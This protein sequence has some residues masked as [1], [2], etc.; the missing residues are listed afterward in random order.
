MK[1]LAVAIVACAAF[2]AAHAQY[3][4]VGPDG[5]VTYTDRPQPGAASVSGA[6]ARSGDVALPLV[7]REATTRFPVTLYT[8]TDCAPC[9][10][11][12]RLLRERGIPHQERIASA[13][14]SEA[15][16]AATG[17]PHVPALMIGRQVLRGFLPSQWHDY[18][19]T[20]GYPRESKL[21]PNYA[22]APALPLVERPAPPQ[23]APRAPEPPPPAPGGFR[24]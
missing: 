9:A 10:G 20:A 4:V 8:S 19:D 11:A 16:L 24:F 13:G 14:E 18:L 1:S 5:R 17:G 23:E 6:A 15:L 3:K 22:Y 2:A 12:R 21:P 7:L